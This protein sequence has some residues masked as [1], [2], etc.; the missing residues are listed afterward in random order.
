MQVHVGDL[1][2]GNITLNDPAQDYQNIV[3][4]YKSV[5]GHDSSGI[6][7]VHGI[8]ACNFYSA[9]IAT[10]SLESAFEN[11]KARPLTP[12]PIWTACRGLQARAARASGTC[13]LHSIELRAAGPGEPAIYAARRLSTGALPNGGF[14]LFKPWS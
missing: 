7:A 4:A 6:E 5:S 12:R 1:S 2:S 9:G 13:I 10:F 11:S 8:A 14:H 3:E